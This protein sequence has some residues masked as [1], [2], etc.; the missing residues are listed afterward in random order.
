MVGEIDQM[1][2]DRGATEWE[3]RTEGW[4]RVRGERGGGVKNLLM[5]WKETLEIFLE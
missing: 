4:S 2:L 1:L 5:K 3:R